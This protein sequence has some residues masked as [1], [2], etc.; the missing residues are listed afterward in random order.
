MRRNP[1]LRR[2]FFAYARDYRTL[3]DAFAVAPGLG[4]EAILANAG[5]DEATFWGSG[6]SDAQLHVL[7]FVTSG[8]RVLE[9]GVG[10]GR[11]ARWVAPHC[12]QLTLVDVSERMLRRARAVLGSDKIR[13]VRSSGSSLASITDSSID[14]AYSLLVLQHLEREDVVRYLAEFRRVLVSDGLLIF[15]LPDLADPTSLSAFVDYAVRERIR[16]VARVRFYTREEIGV[17]LDHFGFSVEDEQVVEGSF[18][19]RARRRP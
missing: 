8:S 18:Y 3:W 1:L 14:I 15:Q 6:Q 17:L 12:A 4:R 5:D 10:I 16:S 11:I 2:V 7:P 19:L 13:Y 9:L